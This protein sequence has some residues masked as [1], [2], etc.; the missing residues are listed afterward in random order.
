VDTGNPDFMVNPA[1]VAALGF[2][3]A[4]PVPGAG[5][6]A[7]VL[8]VPP[9]GL[10]LGGV[11]IDVRGVT[12]SAKTAGGIWGAL[13]ADANLP[14]TVLRRYRVIVDYPNRTLTLAPPAGAVPKGTRVAGAVHPSSGIV[15]ID[16]RIGGVAV[17]LA[18]DL[19]ASYTFVSQSWLERLAADHPRWRRITGAAGA[20]NIWGLWPGEADWPVVRVPA[21]ETGGVTLSSVGIAGLPD[22]FGG[23]SLGAWYS[24]KTARPVEGFLGPN[25]LQAFRVEI[26]YAGEAVYLERAGAAEPATDMDL[27]GLT[28]GPA[29]GGRW[30]VLGVVRQDGRAV[31]DGVE[32]GDILVEVDST[33]IT[34]ASMGRAVDLL[35]GQAGDVR[36]LT[37]ER[38]GRRLTV[39]G[40][41][42]R[43]LGEAGSGGP[44]AEPG[45]WRTLQ[46]EVRT[47]REIHLFLTDLMASAGVPTLSVAVVQDGRIVFDRML[48]TVEPK[49]GP[50]ARSDTVLRAASLSKAVFS[51]LVMR[52]VDEG[53]PR[54][55]V[56]GRA[57]HDLAPPPPSPA[58]DDLQLSWTPGWGSFRSPAGPALFHV[59]IEEGCESYAVFFPERRTGI[60]IQSVSDLRTS[61]SPAI[62]KRLI[63]DT[64]SPFAWMGY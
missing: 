3:P 40:P 25:A 18:L 27:V 57:L 59:G 10:R 52:L 24:K 47:A 34:R 36:R 62:V 53:V 37:I 45:T 61:V 26:D 58:G 13:P 56:T 5:A 20:A 39:S 28:L 32:P 7:P 4:Q 16:G 41:V 31:L 49:G 23:A 6:A 19:G 51:Y 29:D 54:L 35:R 55:R 17:S 1:S 8:L 42:R 60:V 38:G 64:W 30:R 12:P 50:P 9:S 48:G 43:L 2:V 11:A 15:Q 46:G 21:I 14:A 33:P 22:F 44:V 63:G